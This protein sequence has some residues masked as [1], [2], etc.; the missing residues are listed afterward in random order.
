M[1]EG[2]AAV[3]AT[4]ALPVLAHHDPIAFMTRAMEVNA[5]V[6]PRVREDLL[7]WVWG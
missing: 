3:I 5:H 1:D 2:D 4:S 7:T 6:N